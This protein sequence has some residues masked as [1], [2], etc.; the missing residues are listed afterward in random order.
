MADFTPISTQEEFDA[1]VKDRLARA[2]ERYAKK[3]EGYM[4]SDDV[5]KLKT[6]YEQQISGLQKSAD[7]NAKKYA[8]YD[9]QL[10]ER[11]AKIK[12]YETASVKARIAHETGL[13]YD[14]IEFLQG[15]DEKAIKES[16]EKLKK[17]QGGTGPLPLADHDQTGG[18]NKDAAYKKMLANLT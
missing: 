16:A 14:A 4:S 8:D 17:L 2:E 10:A 6:G 3:Y 13:T 7:D 5:A 15:D 18:T 11:D 12:S 9:K 1:M